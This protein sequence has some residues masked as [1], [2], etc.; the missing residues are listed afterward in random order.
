M[1][2][3]KGPCVV[4]VEEL[5][6]KR[7]VAYSSLQPMN[8]AKWAL[9]HRLKRHRGNATTTAYELSRKI[10]LRHHPF[11]DKKPT[12]HKKHQRFADIDADLFDCTEIFDSRCANVDKLYDFE[13][14]TD[15]SHFQPYSFDLVTMPLN[16]YYRSNNHHHNSSGGGGNANS[17]NQ[18]QKSH[19]HSPTPQQKNPRNGQQAPN[20]SENQIQLLKREADEEKEF[21]VMTPTPPVQQSQQPQQ[22]HDTEHTVDMSIPPP[23]RALPMHY[24]NNGGFVQYYYSNTE[25]VDQ[26]YYNNVPAEMMASQPIY[27]LP[28]QAYAAAPIQIQA[29]APYTVAP[30]MP[31]NQM[32]PMPMAAGWPTPGNRT[33]E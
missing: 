20:E 6:E 31:A 14:Y 9:S 13:S 19:R 22:S 5:A 27:Q 26:N 33:S 29:T 1:S 17:Q 11:H 15:L 28:A 23:P 3:N 10:G 32:Y 30:A 12:T 16:T 4:F 18:N 24:G 21:Q 2:P 25:C 7:S 8:D